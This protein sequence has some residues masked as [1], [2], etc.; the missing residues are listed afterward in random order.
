MLAK[1]NK[2]SAERKWLESGTH[3][4][5]LDYKAKRNIVNSK[6][7]IAKTEYYQNVIEI[8]SSD[9]RK[10]FAASKKLLNLKQEPAFTD[11]LFPD[12]QK[13]ANDIGT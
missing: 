12:C 9:Q 4:D 2:L 1:Q 10:L 6:M 7:K 13:L 5:L 8:N 11:H 3:S